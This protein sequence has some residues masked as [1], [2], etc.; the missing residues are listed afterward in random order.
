AQRLVDRAAHRVRRL[1]RRH[2]ALAARE[3]DAGLEAGDLVIGTR[4]DQ[5]EFADM[6]DERRHAVIAQPAG[7]EARRDERRSERVHLDERR[8]MRGVAEI[9]GVFALG[10]GWAG[11]G[12]D[13]DDAA[14]ASTAQLLAQKR[15]SET[16]EV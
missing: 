4:L 12:L 6:R 15:Q 9:I 1:R 14:L 8:E 13:R 5:A 3:L 2:D 11:G 10:Q 7:M 16:G